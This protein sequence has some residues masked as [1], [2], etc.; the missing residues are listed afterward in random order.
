MA[1]DLSNHRPVEAAE[2]D[3]GVRA[4]EA[5]EAVDG[6]G[7]EPGDDLGVLE[8]AVL[9]APRLCDACHER[10]VE[11]LADA[12]GVDG[13]PFARIAADGGVDLAV[14]LKGWGWGG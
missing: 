3:A 5:K 6:F 12:E 4:D 1:V 10:L 7:D 14:F 8:E 9:P 13:D 11:V 2:D